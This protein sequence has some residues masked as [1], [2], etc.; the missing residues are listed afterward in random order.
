MHNEQAAAHCVVAE[1]GLLCVGQRLSR[2]FAIAHLGDVVDVLL[3]IGG[4]QHSVRDGHKHILPDLLIVVRDLICDV[5]HRGCASQLFGEV[6]SFPCLHALDKHGGLLVASDL[7]GGVVSLAVIV[8][9]LIRRGVQLG[10]ERDGCNIAF[11]ADQAHDRGV[12]LDNARGLDAGV[13]GVLLGHVVSE[14]LNVKVEAAKS[15]SLC[16]IIAS[17]SYFARSC[18]YSSGLLFLSLMRSSRLIFLKSS[19]EVPA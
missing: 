17:L 13:D 1:S 9:G 7:S 2:N 12:V 15:A 8:Q 16:H 14:H 3:E 10:I 18:W 11:F 6:L 4:R 5:L 19:G